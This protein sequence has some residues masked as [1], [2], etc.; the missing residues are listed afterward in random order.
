MNTV[1]PCQFVDDQFPVQFRPLIATTLKTAYKTAGR[2]VADEPFLQ[3][4]TAEWNKGRIVSWA[5]DYGFFKLVETGALPF[6]CS[7]EYFA[8][9]TGRYLALRPS[10]SVVTI[11]QIADPTQQPRNVVFRAI[12]RISNTPFFDLPEF[13]D[14]GKIDG[15]PHILL[16][17]GHQDLRFSH[18]CIPD[19]LHHRG[20]RYRTR[21]LLNMPHEIEPEGPPPEDTD[22]DFENL[23]LLKEDI[24][25]WRRDHGGE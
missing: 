16:T 12:A 15:L 8:K 4:P 11:S 2:L 14:E 17:H 25:K 3:T 7:W 1:D 22:T 21:N 9:P 10:H 13:Q 5:V 20:F 19:P 6:D 18:L 24:A 23:N